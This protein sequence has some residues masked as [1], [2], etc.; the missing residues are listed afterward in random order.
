MEINVGGIK[1]IIYGLD[2]LNKQPKRDVAIVFILHGRGENQDGIRQRLI[3][4]KCVKAAS[5]S[6]KRSRNLIAVTFDQRN[7]GSRHLS[8]LQNK[9]WPKNPNHLFDMFSIQQGTSRDVS[10]LIDYLPS[11]LFPNNEQNVVD[12]GCVGS[13]LGGHAT[14]MAL[15]QDER[16]SVGAP[17]IACADYLSLM[18]PRARKHNVDFNPPETFK[19]LIKKYDPMASLASSTD[20]WKGKKIMALSGSNDNLVSPQHQLD[21]LSKLNELYADDD[22]SLIMFKS[23]DGVKHEVNEEMQNACANFIVNA[24]LCNLSKDHLLEKGFQTSLGVC[25]L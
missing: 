17:L 22:A 5:E 7:H 16:I 2:N 23:F 24:L 6:D 11:F 20:V 13:S 9:G 25:K 18:Q 3:A 14:W 8:D 10:Y 1:S 12:F 4:T 19:Q 15:R 21:F